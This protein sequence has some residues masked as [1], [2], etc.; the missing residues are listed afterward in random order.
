VIAEQFGTLQSLYPGRID[1]GLG[2]APGTDPFT[3][4]ALR[5]PVASLDKLDWQ[6]YERQAVFEHLGLALIGGAAK[7]RDGLQRLLEQTRVDELMVTCDFYRFSDRKWALEIL[8]ELR[9]L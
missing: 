1:L 2:R 4:Y 3:A 7:V 8:A 5:P 6:P 9:T